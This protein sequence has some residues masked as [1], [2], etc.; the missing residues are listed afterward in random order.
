MR[1]DGCND[2]DEDGNR[3]KRNETKRND[4][5]IPETHH[6]NNTTLQ[7]MKPIMLKKKDAYIRAQLPDI[8]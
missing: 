2:E 5:K 3:K 6:E 4:A 1:R 7:K 8:T